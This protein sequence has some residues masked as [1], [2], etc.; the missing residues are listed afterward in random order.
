MRKLIVALVSYFLAASCS[1]AFADSSTPGKAIE[2][3]ATASSCKCVSFAKYNTHTAALELEALHRI[4]INDVAAYRASLEKILALDVQG[5]WGSIQDQATSEE[6]R[7]G[8]YGMLRLMAIQNEKFP[9]AAWN[10]DANVTAIFQA[11]IANDP[12]H[13]QLLRRQ[14]WSKPKW[15]NWVN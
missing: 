11:A 5:L 7:N 2:P 10:G 15:V 14:D 4:E 6:D 13:A 12:A 3:A 1:V 8:A 9:I